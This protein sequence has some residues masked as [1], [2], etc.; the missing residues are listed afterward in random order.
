MYKIQFLPHTQNMVRF[1]KRI[2][3]LMLIREKSQIN[4]RILRKK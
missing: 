3:K 2:N 1:N 4:V